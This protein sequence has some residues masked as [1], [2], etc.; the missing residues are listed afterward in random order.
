MIKFSIIV[1]IYNVEKYIE[2][3]IESVINQSYQNWE[4]ILVDDGSPDNCPVICDDYAS[5]D[6]RIA[7]IHKKNGGLPAAR[8]SGIKVA[9]GDYFMHLDGDDFWDIDYLNQVAPIIERDKKDIYLGNSRYDYIDG[10]ATKST[11]FDI[12]EA[13]GKSYDDILQLFFEGMNCMPAAA[14]HNIYATSFI[15]KNNLYLNEKLTW[16]E[17]TD[18]F[19]RV[20]FSTRNIGFFDYTFYYYRKDN[21]GAMTKNPNAKHFISNL[22]VSREWFYKV[23]EMQTISEKTKKII[24]SRFANAQMVSIKSINCLER[25]EFGQVAH[26]IF[27]DKEMLSYISGI[28]Y[29]TIYFSTKVIGCRGTSKLLNIIKR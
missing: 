9:T 21:N 19:Y 14:W 29:K 7:T 8:N 22:S 17:D 10:N 4:L 12:K 6:K 1:P 27:E 2:K 25:K 16:S 13:E 15:K 23:K 26:Y 3:C 24:L 28:I 20:L 5:K 11:L 18:N